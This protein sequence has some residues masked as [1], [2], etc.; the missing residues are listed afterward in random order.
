MLAL[1]MCDALRDADLL[2]EAL[3]DG[4][5]GR[6]PLDDALG[7]YQRRRDEASADD[8][9]DN[10]DAARFKPAR[11][12]V[13]RIRAAIRDKPEETRQFF[14]ARQGMIPRETFFN[15]ENLERLLG[16]TGRSGEQETQ[17]FSD[18]RV[19]PCVTS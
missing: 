4:L 11:D 12:E 18:L 10:L 15:P 14:M 1:G 17:E 13:L 3:D 6:R 2:V 7:D 8:F 16:N 5:S 19:K 9:R